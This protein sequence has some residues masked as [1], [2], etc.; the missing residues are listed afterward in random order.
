MH[1]GL[2]V[3]PWCMACASSLPNCPGGG[4]HQINERVCI[5]LYSILQWGGSQLSW[6]LCHVCRTK[7]KSMVGDTS[8]GVHQGYDQRQEVQSSRGWGFLVSTCTL[9]QLNNRPSMTQVTWNLRWCPEVL[10]CQELLYL[11]RH[12]IFLAWMNHPNFLCG[13]RKFIITSSL[14]IHTLMEIGGVREASWGRLCLFLGARRK[15]TPSIV[16]IV[17]SEL[18]SGALL[19]NMMWA[20]NL[21][22]IISVP[23]HHCP[24]SSMQLLV[25][26]TAQWSDRQSWL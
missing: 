15:S 12:C 1:A 3:A 20:L 11:S 14:S 17:V 19:I 25:F 7:W 16:V 6:G 9:L 18:G 2:V 8:Q 10:W 23:L 22:L 4:A 13:I 21:L 5:L 24:T 26:S